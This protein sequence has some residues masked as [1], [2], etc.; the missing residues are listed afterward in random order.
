MKSST[1]SKAHTIRNL[2]TFVA[3]VVALPWLGW[4]LDMGRGADP[5]NQQNSLGWLLFII[6][7][8]VMSL[9][10]RAVGGAG[11][12]DLGLKPAFKG[13][14]KWYLFSIVFHPVI[15]IL[16]LL[17]GFALGIALIP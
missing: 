6:S 17:G 2:I 5:H 15:T 3:G 10:L 4:G 8:M 13:N 12:K 16:I 11:W 14:G 7:P 9:L 1:N